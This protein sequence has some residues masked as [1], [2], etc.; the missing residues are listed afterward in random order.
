MA[1][2]NVFAQKQT[3]K[4]TH[5]KTDSQTNGVAKNY[6]PLIYRCRDIKSFKLLGNKNLLTIHKS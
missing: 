4:Q 1:N 3:E 6:K 2:V 5:R